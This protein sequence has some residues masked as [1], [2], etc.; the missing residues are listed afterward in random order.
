MMNL[1]GFKF[2]QNNNII[3]VEIVKNESNRGLII[4]R[5]GN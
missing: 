4:I 3:K 1:Q 5:K 2:Y